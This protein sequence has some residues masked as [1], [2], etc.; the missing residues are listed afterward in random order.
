MNTILL[1]GE[2]TVKEGPGN[3]QRGIETVGGRLY[4]TNMRVIFEAHALNGV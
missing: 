1:P 3:M 2:M 4:L